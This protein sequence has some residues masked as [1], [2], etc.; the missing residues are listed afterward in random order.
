V[1]LEGNTPHGATPF[2]RSSLVASG[3][4]VKS[5]RSAKPRV[6]TSR[7]KATGRR[8]RFF[9]SFSRLLGIALTM[10][11]LDCEGHAAN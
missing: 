1:T 7:P 2:G 6:R 11:N 10:S 4:V 3:H 8:R 9:V 5:D